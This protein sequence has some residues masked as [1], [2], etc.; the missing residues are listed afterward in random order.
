MSNQIEN[1]RIAT[2]FLKVRRSKVRVT[3]QAEVILV[4]YPTGFPTG[5]FSCMLI[6]FFY[7]KDPFQYKLPDNLP[8]VFEKKKRKGLKMKLKIRYK[9]NINSI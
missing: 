3:I 7:F 5:Y 6:F 8:G 2:T 9:V 4:D 1:I